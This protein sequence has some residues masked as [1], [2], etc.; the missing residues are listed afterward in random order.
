MTRRAHWE[1]EKLLKP[2]SPPPVAHSFTR[3]T[4]SSSLPNCSTNWRAAIQACELMGAIPVQATT[5][6]VAP[7]PWLPSCKAAYCVLGL[8]QISRPG[9]SIEL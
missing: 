3:T 6:T 8:L 2:D 4:P 5:T 9:A 7:D 1:W